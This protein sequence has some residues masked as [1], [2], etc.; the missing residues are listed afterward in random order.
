[1]LL[2]WAI[3]VAPSV[4][5][6]LLYIGHRKNLLNKRDLLNN[7]MSEEGV[8]DS[9]Q[10]RFGQA[11]DKREKIV[12]G[13]FD[14]YY[15]AGTYWMA[16][17]LN[18]AVVTIGMAIGIIRAGLSL[19]LPSEI[20]ALARKAPLALCMGFAGAYLLSLYDTL[21]R[22]RTSDLSAYSLHFTW[23]HMIL[24]S[25][26]APLVSQ[27]FTPAVGMPVAF[28]LGL[29]PIKDIVDFARESAKK[30]LEMKTIAP[31][32][33][34]TDLSLVQGLN[35]DVIDRLEEEGITSTVELAYYDPIKLFLKTNFQ[36]AWV[37]D[38]MDQ[39]I[40]IN[41]IGDK[42]E[43]LRPVGIRGAI[44]MTVLGE[45]T[46]AGATV[47]Q[48]IRNVVAIVAKRLEM[49][50][51]EARNLGDNLYE[52][53]QVDLLWELFK[54]YGEENSL[55]QPV[56]DPAGGEDNSAAPTTERAARALA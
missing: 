32:P 51:E 3:A 39:A 25:I 16:I 9:Y 17:A 35:K 56:Q 37:I 12:A 36:W 2:L 47:Q 53:G 4:P 23:V 26:L 41:Y 46:R 40:L 42:I 5:Y 28:G 49:T 38:V 27:A 18:I 15:R 31:A 19:G 29:L 48:R 55:E 44:E 6:I 1:M 45:P 50:E 33:K 11:G 20:E 14:L 52:D 7:L 30:K 34:G 13:L 22:C 54:P 8:F 21:R 10:A 24:A 43:V